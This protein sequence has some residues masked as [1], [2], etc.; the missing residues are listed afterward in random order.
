MNEQVPTPTSLIIDG[1]YIHVANYCEDRPTD[2]MLFYSHIATS[3]YSTNRYYWLQGGNVDRNPTHTVERR[4][5][6]Q[7]RQTC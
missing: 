1:F 5:D 7:N 6:G 2:E 4:L 3:L